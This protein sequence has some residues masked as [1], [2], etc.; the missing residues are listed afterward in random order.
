VSGTADGGTRISIEAATRVANVRIVEGASDPEVTGPDLVLQE[1]GP[2]T[3][4]FHF[5]R[6]SVQSA[7]TI[8]L[9]IDGRIL[10]GPIRKGASSLEVVRNLLT[11]LDALY[12]PTG[13]Y[14]TYVAPKTPNPYTFTIRQRLP[15][16]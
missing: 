11:A 5:W 3:F 13:Y 10:R 15:L 1:F 8:G 9:A 7:R 16:R 6:N 12:E 14:V 4:G 2:G